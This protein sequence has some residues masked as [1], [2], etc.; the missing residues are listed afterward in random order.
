ME[1][2]QYSKTLDVYKKE[3]DEVMT[4]V[5][6]FESDKATNSLLQITITK[7]KAENAALKE[8]ISDQYRSILMFENKIRAYE[9]RIQTLES[10]QIANKQ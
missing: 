4:K 2:Q 7:V 1:K 9:L 5:A 10:A 3:L 8:Q 6:S